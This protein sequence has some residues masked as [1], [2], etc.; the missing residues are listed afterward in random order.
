V[1]FQEGAEA[2]AAPLLD[3][4][5]QML[6]VRIQRNIKRHSRHSAG[7]DGDVDV[8]NTISDAPAAEKPAAVAVAPATAAAVAAAATNVAAVTLLEATTQ[9]ANAK[10]KTSNTED[11]VNTYKVGGCDSTNRGIRQVPM[12]ERYRRRQSQAIHTYTPFEYTRLQAHIHGNKQ[13]LVCCRRGAPEYM[14]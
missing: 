14:R 9:P 5:G 1:V 3:E 11:N 8:W 4:P 2:A 12:V 10:P 6:P 13:Q 7:L